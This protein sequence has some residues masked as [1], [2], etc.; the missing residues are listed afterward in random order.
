V[1]VKILPLKINRGEKI[2]LG[3]SIFILA[4]GSCS[5]R[6]TQSTSEALI[7]G[8]LYAS[9]RSFDSTTIFTNLGKNVILSGYTDLAA[10]A[11]SFKTAVDGYTQSCGST[12]ALQNLQSLWRTNIYSLKLIEI[13]QFGPAVQGGYYEIIDPWGNSYL[14][15][16][17]D[18]ASINSFVSG[19]TT[20]NTANIS[21]LNKLQRGIPAI[22]YLLFDD[23]TG[24]SSLNS[25]C[26]NLTGRRLSFLTY[27]VADYYTN[28]QA[29]K[30]AWSE[31]GGNFL[32]ELATAGVGSSFFETKKL[33][34]DMLIT[35]MVTVLNNIVD[36]KLGYPAGLN[37]ASNGTIRAASIE[38]RYADSSTDCLVANL[39]SIQSF[40]NGNGG[41][42]ISN[43]V[44]ASNPILDR[45]ILAQMEDAIAKTKLISNLR[46]SLLGSDLTK[47]RDAYEAV[48]TLRI[49][50][51]TDLSALSGT[52][53]STTTGDGD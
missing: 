10:N 9:L 16:P 26:T 39:I 52:G 25:I 41:A 47:I 14:S 3:L 30:N 53:T 5:R 37:I 15:N 21:A 1:K 20:I 46:T 7:N 51:T 19:S 24:S 42:G 13:V 28:A 33:A 44:K 23:G 35:Q 36:K 43:Y 2:I 40:Y 31:T 22:E 27:L 48:R 50:L 17:P 38:S 18:T 4:I 6:D 49:T 11:S 12:S 34:L 32:N 8:T 29:M 45:K